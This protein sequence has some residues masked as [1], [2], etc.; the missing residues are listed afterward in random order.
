MKAKKTPAK[1]RSSA[2]AR[3]SIATRIRSIWEGAQT[4]ASRSVNTAH[5][6]ANWLIGRE[7]VE[8]QQEGRERAKYGDQLLKKLSE[9]LL[10]DLGHGFS[11]SS[12]QY[13]RDFH[14][15]FPDLLPTQHPP[16]VL[17]FKPCRR[18][19]FNTRRVLNL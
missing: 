18:T 6:V 2:I 19:R 15:R 7:I 17:N 9:E 16:G 10:T 11:V 5:V 1:S 13:M 3:A 12:L 4:Q 8:E 14:L